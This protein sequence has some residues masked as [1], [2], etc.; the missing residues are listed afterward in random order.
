MLS[1]NTNESLLNNNA[2]HSR[3]F[4]SFDAD[5][6]LQNLEPVQLEYPPQP[7]SAVLESLP[8]ASPLSPE[9]ETGSSTSLWAD[10]M[11]EIVGL[12]PTSANDLEPISIH[13]MEPT[14]IHGMEPLEADWEANTSDV[15]GNQEA[16]GDAPVFDLDNG[17]AVGQLAEAL[18]EAPFHPIAIPMI[19]DRMDIETNF[20]V[21]PTGV[22][23]NGHNGLPEE[24]LSEPMALHSR[25]MVNDVVS[26]RPEPAN[27]KT[28]GTIPD[29]ALS[30]DILMGQSPGFRDHPG[31]QWLRELI[32]ERYEDYQACGKKR[33][34]K[35]LIANQVVRVVEAAGG[36]FLKCENSIWVP[37]TDHKKI[38]EKISSDFRGYRKYMNR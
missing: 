16:A 4:G 38:R 5:D 26:K 21:E 8:V 25:R 2:M 29:C 9:S 3:S 34:Q 37:E 14:G 19:N 28:K 20:Q 15:E 24:S 30:T 31:N 6:Q 27:K 33:K 10:V 35:T 13:G 11:A 22:F 23:S 17:A 32:A 36:R 12:E 7:M 18:V 1:Y